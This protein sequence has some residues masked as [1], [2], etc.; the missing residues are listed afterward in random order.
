MAGGVKPDGIKLGGLPRFLRT[1]PCRGVGK[2][3]AVLVGQD[4]RDTDRPAHALQGEPEAV[5]ASYQRQLSEQARRRERE[6]L[7]GAWVETAEA[8][9][10]ALTSFAAIANGDRNLQNGVRAVRRSAAALGRRI[11]T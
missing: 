10:T 5:P 4:E 3:L 1:L 8:I 9:D 7:R 2:R 11:A 6:R